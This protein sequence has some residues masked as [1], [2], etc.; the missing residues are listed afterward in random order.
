MAVRSWPIAGS[1]DRQL[2]G[3]WSPCRSWG[4]RFE[5]IGPAS[6]AMTG[7]AQSGREIVA[8]TEMMRCHEDRNGP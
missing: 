7:H 5:V 4:T 1:D 8:G 2:T 6:T 3:V